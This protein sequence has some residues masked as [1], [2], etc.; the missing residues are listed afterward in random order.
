LHTDF[1]SGVSFLPYTSPAPNAISLQTEN[2]H[3]R[4]YSPSFS[5]L[6]AT[7]PP[8][9]RLD[10]FLSAIWF[11]FSNYKSFYKVAPMMGRKE[12]DPRSMCPQYL[13]LCKSS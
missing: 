5:V 4:I 7:T 13:S 2:K 1:V 9:H 3:S 6:N 12:G 11:L 10:F 8:H